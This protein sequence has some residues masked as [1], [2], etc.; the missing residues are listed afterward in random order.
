MPT[1]DP[2]SWL[3]NPLV[4]KQTGDSF[5]S[6]TRGLRP[7]T[8]LSTL[9]KDLGA[10]EGGGSS[11]R[12]TLLLRPG[13]PPP[14]LVPAGSLS[15]H[16]TLGRGCLCDPDSKCEQSVTQRPRGDRREGGPEEHPCLVDT[17]AKAGPGA[18]ITGSQSSRGAPGPRAGCPGPGA[19]PLGSSRFAVS[20]TQA[21]AQA[22]L[23]VKSPCHLAI[24][25][26]QTFP[27]G[28][29]A[30]PEASGHPQTP[31]VVTHLPP[32]GPPLLHGLPRTRTHCSPGSRGVCPAG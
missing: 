23:A 16:R 26:H 32:A 8:G 21:V 14:A 13:L 22:G 30:A 4:S 18:T 6:A 29:V 9:G 3:S 19:C 20:L 25:S 15:N 12:V 31:G 2:R 1:L 10:P 7:L 27:G 24:S 17:D 28:A 11:H 5:P